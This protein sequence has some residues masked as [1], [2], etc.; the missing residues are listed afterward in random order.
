MRWRVFNT[1]NQLIR[2]IRDSV[3][4]HAVM[5][6]TLSGSRLDGGPNT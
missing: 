3:G 4:G 2:E 5:I 1:V 6:G